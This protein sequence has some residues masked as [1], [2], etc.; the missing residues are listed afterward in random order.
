M[1]N[2]SPVLRSDR[3]EAFL[4]RFGIRGA[5]EDS[6]VFSAGNYWSLVMTTVA[7]IFARR[8]IDPAAFGAMAFAGAFLGYF[9]VGNSTLANAVGREVPRLDGSGQ[10]DRAE[11][12]IRIARGALLVFVAIEAMILARM[13]WSAG[14]GYR[15]LAFA[16]AAVSAVFAG[17]SNLDKHILKSRRWFF[18]VATFDGISGTLTAAAMLLFVILWQENGYF[19]ALMTGAIA[20]AI[21]ARVLVRPISSGARGVALRRD[22]LGQI[23]MAG[24]PMVILALFTKS[25]SVVD[26]FFVEFYLGLEQLG[27]YSLASMFISSALM[28]PQAVAGSYMPR[29][30]ALAGAGRRDLMPQKTLALQQAVLLVAYLIIGLGLLLIPPLLEWILPTYVVVVT[31][32]QIL[33]ANVFFIGMAQ[34]AYFVHL[35][36]DRM[37]RMIWAAFAGVVVGLILY[38][39][40][41]P[42]GL[43]G[44]AIASVS[45]FATYAFVGVISAH[46]VLPTPGIGRLVLVTTAG[47]GSLYGA[48]F[49]GGPIWLG[50]LVILTGGASLVHLHAV[51]VERK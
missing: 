31:P 28:L 8:M 17:H 5:A 47:L 41:T 38:P 37:R 32:L 2:R 9:Q 12:L 27:F 45:S 34:A 49:W 23:T 40:L 44:A 3:P 29:Y 15:Q 42:F 25:L 4:S 36:F 6:V 39:I 22:V 50:G 43:T 19:A 48:L 13:A 30:L 26:R 51:A 33:L 46:R 11:L 21:V 16:T 18:R 20:G 24:G 35:G 1:E 14:G 10:P 7:N